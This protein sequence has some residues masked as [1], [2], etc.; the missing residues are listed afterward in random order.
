MYN[1]YINNDYNV[2]IEKNSFLLKYINFYDIISFK[3]SIDYNID[4]LNDVNK[5][6]ISIDY[7]NYKKQDNNI[8]NLI[9]NSENNNG[10]EE[11]FDIF[12]SLKETNNNINYKLTIIKN[13]K[14]KWRV[15][16]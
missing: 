5:L 11:I 12:K 4:F 14:K 3:N 15:N 6:D 1:K 9:Y 8:I 2:L 10:I 16:L 13:N 7:L